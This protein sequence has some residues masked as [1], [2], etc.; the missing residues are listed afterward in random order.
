MAHTA[1]NYL[2]DLYK[3]CSDLDFLHHMFFAAEF[4]SVNKLKN[5]KKFTRESFSAKKQSRNPHIV[6]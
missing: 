4:N 6:V 3:G 2:F 1:D 5:W